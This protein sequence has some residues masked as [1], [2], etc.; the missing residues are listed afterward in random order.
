MCVCVIK[1]IFT[2][3]TINPHRMA[4]MQASLYLGLLV[5]LMSSS[6]ILQMTS[7]VAM[8]VLSTIS[9]FLALIYVIFFMTESIQRLEPESRV[10]RL[11]WHMLYRFAERI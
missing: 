10:V 1:G 6:Y 8:F 5:G 9:M 3:A 2:T 7:V 11:P 4:I